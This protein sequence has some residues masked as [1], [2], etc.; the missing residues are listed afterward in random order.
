MH[1]FYLPT[2]V[3]FPAKK[4]GYRITLKQKHEAYYFITSTNHNKEIMVLYDEQVEK[5]IRIR[6]YDADCQ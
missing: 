6:V 1:G 5:P 2:G 4:Y 3:E